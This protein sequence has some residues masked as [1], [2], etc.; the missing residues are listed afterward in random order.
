M[1][2]RLAAAI[3]GAVVLIGVLYAYSLDERP[4]VAGSNSVAPFYATLPLPSGAVRCHGI[5][6][7]PAKA[8]R[9]RVIATA[10][11]ETHGT[12]DVQLQDPSGKIA[13]GVKKNIDRGALVIRLNRL[14]RPTHR[15]KICFANR[16]DGRIVLSGED[17]RLKGSRGAR[18][19]RRGVPSVVFLRPRVSTWGARRDLIAER[20]ANA[21]PG[22]FG[23]WSLWFAV[24][25]LAVA[26]TLAFWWLIFRLEPG[27]K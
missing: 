10:V 19:E 14:T 4:M 23:G 6:R 22:A 5:S 17:K 24:A 25:L 1:T 9:V 26:V 21:Q 8:N 20:F 2:R 27:D 7:I 13:K 11:P 16:G 18:G 12:L 3:A 15:A